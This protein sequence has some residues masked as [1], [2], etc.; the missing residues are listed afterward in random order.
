MGVFDG[1]ACIGGTTRMMTHDLN[2]V[3]VTTRGV[4]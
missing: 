4:G 1:I 2:G 3:G